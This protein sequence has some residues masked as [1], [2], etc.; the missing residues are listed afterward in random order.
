MG[1]NLNFFWLNKPN[2][3]GFD[4]W[5]VFGRQLPLAVGRTPPP[6]HLIRPAEF[7]RLQ[8]PSGVPSCRPSPPGCGTRRHRCG[9]L[10]RPPVGEDGCGPGLPPIPSPGGAPPTR[11][12][13]GFGS[14]WNAPER[15]EWDGP[16]CM[17]RMPA[18]PTVMP[19]NTS[20]CSQGAGETWQFFFGF[21]RCAGRD[22]F[23]SGV[24]R[25]VGRRCLFYGCPMCQIV[26]CFKRRGCFCKSGSCLIHIACPGLL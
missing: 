3:A 18:G 22:G 2:T 23:S 21:W 8:H 7:V 19:I 13:S 14:V 4:F 26:S 5:P 15:T 17:E 1:L 16:E 25:L 11:I 6:H 12:R 20:E 24:Y 10:S 9:F